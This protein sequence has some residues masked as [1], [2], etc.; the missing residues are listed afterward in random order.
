MKSLKTLQTLS[1]VGKVLSS[2]VFVLS[3]IAG[4]IVALAFVFSLTLKN[5][6]VEN[7]QTF[8]ELIQIELN[9][10]MP[11]IYL[12]LI[13]SFLACVVE[14][15]SCKMAQKYFK[16]ELSVGTP[17]TQEGAKKMLYLGIWLLVL[18]LAY[19]FVCGIIAAIYIALNG[20]IT[21]SGL[22]Y[23]AFSGVGVAFI[24]VSFILKYGADIS[25]DKVA[26]IDQKEKN[27]STSGVF[28]K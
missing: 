8:E 3:I 24:V 5:V 28:D 4:C 26:K 25:A 16:Y 12:T 15:I 18:P 9:M 13:C 27:D 20:N 2:I 1:K 14:A 23:S 17:F 22:S 21:F 10:T 7:E 11:S 19:G 6:I